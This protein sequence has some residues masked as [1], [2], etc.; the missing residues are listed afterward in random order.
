MNLGTKGGADLRPSSSDELQIYTNKNGIPVN[1]MPKA[2]PTDGQT[3][4]KK[5]IEYF[6]NCIKENKEPSPSAE[7]SLTIM[8]VIDAIYKL[9]NRG[10]EIIVIN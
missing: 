6:I 4:V 10:G 9:S 5:E 3:M 7:K 2:Q 8:R 1:I